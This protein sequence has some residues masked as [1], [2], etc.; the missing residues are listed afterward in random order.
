MTQN[1]T[2]WVQSCSAEADAAL[3][4]TYQDSAKRHAR[5]VVRPDLSVQFHGVSTTYPGIDYLD[6]ALQLATREVVRNAIQA[7]QQ[8]YAAFVM[9]S[10]NDSGN[11]EVREL[12]DF[13]AVFITETAVHFAAQL[14]GKFAFLTHN[15]GARKKMELMTER[16]GLGS[17]LVEGASLNMTYQDFTRIYQDPAAGLA[18]FTREARKVI[19]RGA[20]ILIPV[21]GPL[22]MFFVDQ[23]FKQVDGVPLL[24]ILAVAL[25]TA[26]QLIDLNA[27]GVPQRGASEV[28]PEFKEKLRALF[29]GR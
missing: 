1:S 16:Y 21:G 23:G 14:G 17:L 12:T 13:P 22:N 29:L 9:I 10:T 7:E 28:K 8:A 15:P 18:E 6:G 26:E 3:W 11:R 4:T 19:A 24:D 5:K 2:I 20:R 27:L 25:K